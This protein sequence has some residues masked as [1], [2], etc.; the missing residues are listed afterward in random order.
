[1]ATSFLA[2]LLV[3]VSFSCWSHFTAKRNLVRSVSTQAKMVAQNCQAAITFEDADGAK[4]T[5]KSLSVVPSIFCGAIYTTQ[6]INFASYTSNDEIIVPSRFEGDEI[7][8][9]V[10]LYSNLGPVK[11]I[12]AQNIQIILSLLVIASLLTYLISSKIQTIISGPI[13]RLTE[14]ASLVSRK[15]D[16]SVR[17]KKNNDDEIGLLIDSFNYMLEQIQTEI[18]DRKRAEDDIVKLNETLEQRVT[19]RTAELEKTHTQL[20]VASHHAGMAEVATDVLHNVG[21]VLNSVNVQTTL[22]EEKIKD[23]K[24]KNIHEISEMIDSHLDDISSYLEQDEKG[25]HIPQYLC[26]VSEYMMKEQADMLEKFSSLIKNINHIKEIISMQQSYAKTAGISI[27]TTI[28]EVVNDA[29][30][31]N[32]AGLERHGVE[33]ICNHEDIG[34]ISLDRQRIVQILVNLIGNAKYAVTKNG[35]DEKKIIV[36]SYKQNDECVIEVTD[37]GLGMSTENLTKIFGHGFTTKADGH[38]FGLHS[39][40]IAAKEMGGSLNAHSDGPDK[41]A[42]LKLVIPFR[43]AEVKN[44]S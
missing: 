6:G 32:H 26:D 5:L 8:G 43:S 28:K 22:I 16:Y 35:R 44:G 21:N 3:G 18:L 30:Q 11:K 42:T 40:A 20:I 36:K 19:S 33:L 4:D 13:L 10:V 24:I 25:K 34:K 41:G 31:I 17:A 27:I 1:M 14:V 15:K 39:G 7:I 9:T 37:N 38:G 29:I 23:S 2:L 12:L